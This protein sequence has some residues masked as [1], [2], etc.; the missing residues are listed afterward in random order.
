M[1]RSMSFAHELVSS[2]PPEQHLEPH[3]DCEVGFGRAI[4]LAAPDYLDFPTHFL[5]GCILGSPLD[6]TWEVATR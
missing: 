6:L 3:Y 5:A 1:P 2:L 4:D